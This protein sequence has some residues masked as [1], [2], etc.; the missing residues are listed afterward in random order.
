MNGLKRHFAHRRRGSTNL[1][2]LLVVS[3]ILAG[4]AI[5]VVVA[6]RAA[7]ATPSGT[8][9]NNPLRP[10]STPGNAA[11][12]TQSAIGSSA[13]PTPPNP[14]PSNP[15][16]PDTQPHAA[17]SQA[18][19]NPPSSSA[20]SD[21]PLDAAIDTAEKVLHYL[22]HGVK[23]YTCVIAKQSR[24]EG[25]LSPL[26]FMAV[27]IRQKPFSVYLNFLKP[28]DVRGRE[29]IY[30]SGAN[31]GKLLVRDGS[32]L[33]RSLGMLELSPTGPIVMHDQRYPITDLGLTHLTERLLEIGRQD[34]KRGNLEVNYFKNA[35]VNGRVCDAIQV[36]HPRELPGFLFYKAEV[37]IDHELNVPIRYVAYMW[38]KKPGEDP[39]IDESY[40]YLD[41]KINVGLTDADFDPHNSNYHFFDK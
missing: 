6:V 36:I 31:D 13:Q 24:L 15:S 30:V 2:V 37:Y 9:P 34:R 14:T 3:A 4:A 10:N 21:S 35:K 5:A 20:G 25:T 17:G 38:P 32:G 1:A 40:T 7:P 16:Q 26:E 23:D 19:S 29:V 39:P 11:P 22:Q 12:T 28:E 41:L 27:K 33:T 8:T 18:E